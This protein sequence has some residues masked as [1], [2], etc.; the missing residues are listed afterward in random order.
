MNQHF[1][2]NNLSLNFNNGTGDPTVG[3]SPIINPGQESTTTISDVNG[4]LLFYSDGIQ[5]YNRNNV[6]MPNG[7]G[8]LGNSS[9]TQSCLATPYPGNPNW[10]YLFTNDA[11]ENNLDNG[12]RYNI[13]DM[14]LANGLGDIIPSTKNTLIRD[15]LG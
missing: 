11:V 13:I 12:L 1:Y 8:L 2:F 3:T 15:D 9:S 7:S 6:V 14:T 10:Y 5:V 4:N